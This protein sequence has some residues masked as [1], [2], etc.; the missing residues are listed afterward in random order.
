MSDHESTTKPQQ[1]PKRGASPGASPFRAKGKKEPSSKSERLIHI[2]RPGVVCDTEPRGHE[3]PRGRSLAELVLDASE[4]FIPLWEKDMTLRWRFRERSM[5]YFMNPA[6]AKAEIRNLFSEALLAWGA[7]AP[8]SFKEDDDLW[9]FEIVMMAGDNCTANGCV[10]ASAFFPDAGRHQLSLY[11]KLFAQV[12]QEQVETL[13]HELGHVFGL[14]H[15]F[16]NISETQWPS[17]IFGVH[18]R[19]TIMNYGDDSK[20]TDADKS[21]LTHLYQMAW[22]GALT[23]VNGTP[24]RFVKPFSTLAPATDG[25]FA[26]NPNFAA[27]QP[28]VRA[29][30]FGI[31]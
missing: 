8:I 26:P 5:E 27:L 21:D 1:K 28:A 13:I 31:R 16:A 24:I 10:L 17:E 2:I 4:G 18:Q 6:A 9:D 3:T 20:L 29:A 15:F 30:Y 19:F 25:V 11:P 23:K 22:S 7:A 14:R 12:R